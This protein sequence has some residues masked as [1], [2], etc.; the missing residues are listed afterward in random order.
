MA[1]TDRATL[2]RRGLLEGGVSRERSTVLGLLDLEN[3]RQRD[4][5]MTANQ[6]LINRENAELARQQA[7]YET[8]M[9]FKSEQA[10]DQ[11]QQGY[12]QSAGQLGGTVGGIYL[13][14]KLLGAGAAGGMSSSLAGGG[15]AVGGGAVTTGTVATGVA[16]GGVAARGTAAGGTAA[17]IG[18]LP[19]TGGLL[20]ITAGLKGNE[21]MRKA[22]GNNDPKGFGEKTAKLMTKTTPFNDEDEFGRAMNVV[23]PVPAITSGA[24]DMTGTHICTELHRQGIMSDEMYDLD[25]KY[26]SQL[27]YNAIIG[28]RV[29]AKGVADKMAESALFTK[30]VCLFA[31][32]WAYEMAHRMKPD[33]YK[34]HWLGKVIIKAGVP[35]CRW[36][37]RNLVCMPMKGV[38]NV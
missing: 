15:T 20:A 21:A 38:Q 27:D 28:Y 29:W 36:I 32:P 25:I 19:V 18:V 2:R 22:Q 30:I 17:G 12:Y 31:L 34:G 4:I 23:F 3:Q 26:A 16:E 35:I 11:R 37:G 1:Y 9:A 7:N 8:E 33:T 13:G 5:A 24:A 6:S 14:S 10:K